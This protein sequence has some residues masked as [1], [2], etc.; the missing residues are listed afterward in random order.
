VKWYSVAGSPPGPPVTG[1]RL[2]L[3]RPGPRR[4]AE[5]AKRRRPAGFVQFDLGV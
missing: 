3:F 5:E 4:I 1:R 2:D